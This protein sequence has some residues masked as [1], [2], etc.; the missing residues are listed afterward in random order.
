[1]NQSI[2]NR[3]FSR[4]NFSAAIA[5]SVISI[6]AFITSLKIQIPPSYPDFIVGSISWYDGAK[7]QDLISAPVFIFTL[8]L[9]FTFFSNQLN[10]LKKRFDN[11]YV[12]K[13]TNQFLLW[14]IP[15]FIAIFKLFLG[16]EVE[17]SLITISVLGVGFIAIFLIINS[18]SKTNFDPVLIGLSL[19]AF[20]L[21]SY[22]PLELALIL[23]R[24]PIQLVG[25]I[26]LKYFIKTQ[27]VFLLISCVI[28]LYFILS[29]SD[30]FSSLVSRLLLIG[31]LGLLTLYLT[32]YPARLLQPSGEFT[33]YETTIWLKFL[34]VSMILLGAI[35][36]I[37]RFRRYLYSDAYMKF[38]SPIAIFALL[39]ASKTGNTF[40]PVINTD[41]YHFGES[42]LGWW[43]YLQGAIPYVDY[44]PAHGLIDDDMDRFLSSIFY[45]GSAGSISDVTRLTFFILGFVAFISIYL[46]SGSLALS[47]IAILLMDVHRMGWFYLIPFICLWFSKSLRNNPDKWLI[48]WLFSVPLVI[49][50][51]PPQGFLLVLSSTVMAAYFAWLQVNSPVKG[52]Y[53]KVF[54]SLI[55]ITLLIVA[56]PLGIMLSAAIRYVLE[57]GPINQMAWGIPW[58][59]SWN[60]VSVK[61]GF[62]FEL[63]RMSWVLIP[64][65]CLIL[66]YKNKSDW[67]NK[68]SQIFP[69]IVVLVFI[70]LLI[71]YSMGRID[72]GALSRQG[73]VSIYTWS[74]LL[75]IIGSLYLSFKYTTLLTFLIACMCSVL[76]MQNVSIPLLYASSNQFVNTPPLIDGESF[77]LKNIGTA[78]VDGAH[79][80]RLVR[81]N[82]LLNSKLTSDE[83][84]LDLT[85]RNAQY[86]YLNRKPVLQ[87]TAPYNMVSL[88]QQKRAVE[89]LTLNLPKIALLEGLNIVHDGGGLAL[90]N[91]YL[92]RF[93]VESYIPSYEN[94]FIIGK[95]KSDISIS[96]SS[97][98]KFKVMDMNDENWN[99]GF[100]RKE[101]AIVVNNPYLMQLFKVGDEIRIGDNELR[102]ITKV[103]LEGNAI[104]YDGL[105]IQMT[106]EQTSID[107]IFIANK[108]TITDYR[109]SLLQKSFSISDYQK[110][111]VSWG[112]SEK[113]LNDKMSH[114][115]SFDLMKSATHDLSYENGVYIVRGSD[116]NLSLDFS[117][118]K[119]SGAQAGLLKFDFVCKDKRE[120]PRMQVFWW[121]DQ[122]QSAFEKSSIRFTADNGPLIIPLDASPFW[123]TLDTINGIRV[124][125]DNPSACSS[126]TLENLALYQRL[127]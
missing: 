29:K 12:E 90:R 82:E 66:V 89:K 79:L 46:F 33:K 116:P 14:S 88:K 48:V 113:S 21:I 117:K 70:L 72:P 47:F 59:L 110:I 57:N 9:S 92:Y 62:V 5:A 53:F 26:H 93:I 86:F 58:T 91:P 2:I 124:D 18:K 64:I 30:K 118:F 8:F 97:E 16:G 41:D 55:I 121:G 17:H 107:A 69:T 23:S 7:F 44:L 40:Y 43:S 114:V 120:E 42:L 39:F 78:N 52:S 38:F 28:F 60:S 99:H 36:V 73:I 102:K 74:I 61:H 83:T 1:M 96:R 20:A 104:W 115:Q 105:P 25:D 108:Q 54:I 126:F 32:L 50:G 45:D 15:C 98:I 123:L 101:A 122:H 85:S 3:S 87:V 27:Y 51:V 49:L 31:Q 65:L 80:D 125:L 111:P 95:R 81:L 19:F 11:S 37:K 10:T 24:L 112:K 34:I 103:W 22:L 75:P 6:W 84:Y 127:F 67:A 56:T 76:S 109:L 106:D 68:D 35:D 13:L 77:G 4:E 63:I 119:I 71:P 100:H 94:G